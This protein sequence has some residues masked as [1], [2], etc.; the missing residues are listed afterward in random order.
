M[1]AVYQ[2]LQENQD[3][4]CSELQL[5]IVKQFNV[6]MEAQTEKLFH[7]DVPR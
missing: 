5:D 6:G 1:T 7:F 2:V 3:N 4:M